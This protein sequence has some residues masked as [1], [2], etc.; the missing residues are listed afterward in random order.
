MPNNEFFYPKEIEFQ[1]NT[2]EISE[3]IREK[4]I[5]LLGDELPYE[6]AVV[7]ELIKRKKR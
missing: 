6:T 7:I 1:S 3:T 5:R 4:V 2:F